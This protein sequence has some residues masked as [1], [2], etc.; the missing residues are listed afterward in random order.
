MS[1][2]MW[3]RFSP[4]HQSVSGGIGQQVKKV[5]SESVVLSSRKEEAGGDGAEG[6]QD[7]ESMV[8]NAVDTVLGERT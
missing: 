8:Q 7:L 5:E 2:A 1:P 6:G 4:E 3:Y